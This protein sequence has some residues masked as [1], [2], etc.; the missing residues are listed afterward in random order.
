MLMYKSPS[1]FVKPQV[2]NGY[3]L[4]CSR[5]RRQA[6]ANCP[7]CHPDGYGPMLSDPF[8][9]PERESIRGLHFPLG[10]RPRFTLGFKVCAVTS[11]LLIFLFRFLPASYRLKVRDSQLYLFVPIEDFLLFCHWFVERRAFPS[12]SASGPPW[13]SVDVLIIIIGDI[14]R[15]QVD[16]L[17]FV[18]LRILRGRRRTFRVSLFDGRFHARV[19]T[20]RTFLRGSRPVE[21]GCKVES[22]PAD[23]SGSAGAD[24]SSPCR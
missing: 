24:C 3:E 8:E 17:D 11:R 23:F 14:A 10:A 5:V 22:F 12:E 15:I 13:M 20:R 18:I 9:Y 19:L 16:L 4:S 1:S 6:V 2:Q 7:S 21:W